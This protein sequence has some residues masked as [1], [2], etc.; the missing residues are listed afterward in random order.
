MLDFSTNCS[1][2]CQY[3]CKLCVH[4]ELAVQFWAVTTVKPPFPS[5]VIWVAFWWRGEFLSMGA[6]WKAA[7]IQWSDTSVNHTVNS[8]VSSY[9]E[10]V[11]A[12]L[13]GLPIT[14]R[15][16]ASTFKE[17]I[18]MLLKQA[19]RIFIGVRGN[20]TSLLKNRK[21]DEKFFLSPLISDFSFN[22]IKVNRYCLFLLIPR[23]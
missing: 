13:R 20:R 4:H 15:V 1:D 2:L 23:F 3:H 17:V 18:T 11:T 5:R 8:T 9:R 7:N 19:F 14:E 21:H 16:K 12:L 22:D 6:N 10:I